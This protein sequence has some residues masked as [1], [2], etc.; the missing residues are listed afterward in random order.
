MATIIIII[1]YHIVRVCVGCV[2][3]A[4]CYINSGIAMFFMHIILFTPQHHN[5]LWEPQYRGYNIIIWRHNNILV[6]T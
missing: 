5:N 4:N 2:K 6:L 1:M 3:Q